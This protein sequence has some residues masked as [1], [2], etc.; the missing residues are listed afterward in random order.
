MTPVK[1]ALGLLAAG[2]LAT[3]TAHAAVRAH[4]AEAAPAP[5]SMVQTQVLARRG[6]DDRAGDDRGR[7][8]KRH[9]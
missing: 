6:A 3:T 4:G 8:G 2:L 7:R 1:L 5:A 9:G